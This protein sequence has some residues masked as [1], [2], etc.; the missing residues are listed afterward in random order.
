[1]RDM[2]DLSR[3]DLVGARRGLPQPRGCTRA[4]EQRC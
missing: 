1:M 4:A 3:D 2:T